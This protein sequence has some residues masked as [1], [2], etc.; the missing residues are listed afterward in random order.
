MAGTHSTGSLVE[1]AP[2]S[3]AIVDISFDVGGNG[4]RCCRLWSGAGRGAGSPPICAATE[5]R[6][7]DRR[8]VA[9]ALAP[10]WVR[11]Q[12]A[13]CPRLRRQDRPVGGRSH[14]DG[15]AACQT[16]TDLSETRTRPPSIPEF[17]PPLAW[18]THMLWSLRPASSSSLPVGQRRRNSVVGPR[19]LTFL[20]S[21]D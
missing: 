21:L 4:A 6:P 10:G 1:S 7:I 3:G 15:A 19:L 5:A 16:G 13:P 20:L 2:L 8:L 9:M 12:R 11:R 14:I 18:P 17:R